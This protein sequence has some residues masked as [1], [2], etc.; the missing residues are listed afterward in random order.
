M[1]NAA[2]I[3]KERLGLTKNPRILAS[4]P[5]IPKHRFDCVNL[6]LKETKQRLARLS[7]ELG[8]VKKRT[9]ELETALLHTA[10]EKSLAVH[11]AKNIAAAKALIDLSN[12]KLGHD[13]AV[14][15]LEEAILGIK[16]SQSYLFEGQ[17][18]AYILVPVR[19]GDSRIN[20]RCD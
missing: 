15:G 4:E 1:E 9:E 19:R 12:L 3:A 17:D 6:C 16:E 7:A 10:V 20:S 18:E 8:T 14:P 13:G 5:M 2:E 11:R